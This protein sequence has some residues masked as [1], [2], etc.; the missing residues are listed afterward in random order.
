MYR[1]FLQ[2]FIILAYTSFTKAQVKSNFGQLPVQNYT[3][4]N[5]KAGNQNWSIT[6]D[7][8]G[9]LYYGNNNGL[10]EF[11]GNTWQLHPLPNG[12]I[13][14]SVASDNMGRIYIGSFQEFGYFENDEYGNLQYTSLSAM[15]KNYDFHN[16]EIWKIIIHKD[17]VYFQ[18]FMVVFKYCK[19]KIEALTPGGLISCFSMVN[20]RLVLN[21]NG[22]GL[23]ELDDNRFTKI[24]DDPFFKNREISVILPYDKEKLLIATN[25]EGIYLF[26]PKTGLQ[27]WKND[28]QLSLE[29]DQ[30]NRGIVSPEGNIIIGTILNGIYIFSKDG[31][32]L[33]H[34]NKQNGLQNNTVLDL[35]CDRYGDLWTGLDRGVDLIILNSDI[36]FLY[37]FSGKLGSVYSVHLLDN[38]LYL[39]TNQGLYYCPVPKND[40]KPKFTGFHFINNSQ[41]Q[42]WNIYYSGNQLLCGHN[43]GTFE[44]V[45]DN[46]RLLSNVSGGLAYEYF[47]RKN[48]EYL[49]GCTYTKLVIYEKNNGKWNYRNSVEDFM[50]PVKQIKIDYLGNIWASHFVKGLYRLKLNDSMTRVDKIDFYGKSKGFISDNQINVSR[51]ENRIIFINHGKL[52]T[53]ND[54]LDSVI[55]FESF[56][57]QLDKNI[58]IKNIT[59]GKSGY[60]WIIADQ[61]IIY[62][63]MVDDKWEIKKIFS[64]DLFYN[65]VVSDQEF[66]LPLDNGD[67][68]LAL[69]NGLAYIKTSSTTN[70]HSINIVPLLIKVT[71]TNRS[72]ISLPVDQ[73]NGKEFPILS[74]RNNNLLF[75]FSFPYYHGSSYFLVKLQGLDNKWTRTDLAEF[76]Y[77]RI[78]PGKYSFML[79]AVNADGSVSKTINWSFQVDPP[80]YMT[81]MARFIYLIGF[82]ALLLYIRYYFKK[83]LKNQARRMKI[84][85]ERELIKLRNEKLE[86][87]INHKTKELANTTFS[88]IKKN[89]MLF[90]IRR[91]LIQQKRQSSTGATPKYTDIVKLIDRNITSE[92]DWKIFE[93]NFEQA[94]E[95]F[96]K[97]IKE[98]IPDLTPSDLKLC[99]YLRMNLSSK[100]IALLLGITIRG[101]E[102]HRYRLR[103]KIGLEHDSNLIDFLMKF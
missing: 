94:H 66:I 92:D 56:E 47:T 16:E 1:L 39:G 60:F 15:L 55:R 26:S 58:E 75:H 62:A 99:A 67:A 43:K 90:D 91:K 35:F 8:K 52:F 33:Q 86:T 5:Y 13:T 14:R 2:I 10:L 34:I 28:A 37:D 88:I 98:K 83:R 7:K 78:P 20:N 25:L 23:F 31:S 85:K 71:S 76:R 70:S 12:T 49:I 93:N 50:N 53:Y 74:Y 68:I 21:I 46:L 65:K 19:D 100:K 3:R 64:S 101:V 79:K 22:K 87:E 24:S 72:E 97:R 44:V 82:V 42:V 54:L 77:D 40:D 89:E 41:G 96:L 45:G 36:S 80:W 63:R 9:I 29:H 11:N 32:L 59:A 30:V 6:Q 4:L 51:L 17:A 48:K 61:G 102:N 18:S 69:D 57:K 103:K 84:E 95:E 27:E 81:I 73:D 38:K